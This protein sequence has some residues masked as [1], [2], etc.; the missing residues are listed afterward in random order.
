M[1]KTPLK[2]E[3]TKNQTKQKGNEENFPYRRANLI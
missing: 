3:N 1:V 2:I